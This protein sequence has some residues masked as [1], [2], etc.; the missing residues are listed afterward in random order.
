MR[1]VNLA[2]GGLDSSLVSVLA[3]EQNIE[4]F[5]L[6][7]D[8][9][10]R[11]AAMEWKACCEV[12]KKIKTVKPVRMDISGFGKV[13]LSGLTSELLDIRKDAF[14]PCRNLLFLVI[15]A[16][17]AYQVGADSVSIGLLSEQFSLFPDQKE[18][19]IHTAEDAIIAALGKNIKIVTPLSEFSKSDVIALA[20]RKGLT[21]TYSCHAGGLSP[22][23]K[24]I[25]CLEFQ[26]NTKKG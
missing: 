20:H 8:Y 21:N 3:S 1:I 6:F 4:L 16:S 25:S 22:C 11:A 13:I 23:N 18:N 19:F 2:S 9:G 7:I 26:G 5:P 12:H 10:Q 15:G 24:C 14:T 17:Y